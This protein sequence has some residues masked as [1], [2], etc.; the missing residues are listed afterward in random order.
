MQTI[1]FFNISVF[2]NI[3]NHFIARSLSLSLF[4]LSMNSYCVT[5]N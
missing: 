3:D 5:I 1:N 4:N 2:N